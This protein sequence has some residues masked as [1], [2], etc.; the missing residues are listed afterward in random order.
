MTELKLDDRTLKWIRDGRGFGSGK[1]YVPWLT[2]RDVSSK[3]RVHRVQGHLSQRTHH[4]LSDLEL[5]TFLL[6]EWNPRVSDIREQF[7]LNVDETRQIAEE[8]GIRHPAVSG[9]TQ[10]MSSDF[11]VDMQHSITGTVKKLAIQVKRNLPVVDK[12]WR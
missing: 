2:V 1:D 12:R 8:L 6:L 4:L 7:P 3:G 5:S 11:L 9:N 10:V